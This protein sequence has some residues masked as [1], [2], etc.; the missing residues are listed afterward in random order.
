VTPA[1]FRARLKTL[2]LSLQDFSALTGANVT[3]VSY[4]GRERP[5]AGF[6]A[7]PRWVESL[8]SAWERSPPEAQREKRKLSESCA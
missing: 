3:T 1:D 6:Q 7:F 4:W 2:G 8:V 5:G